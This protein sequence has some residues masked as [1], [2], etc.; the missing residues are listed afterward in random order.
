MARI[1]ILPL[2][3]QSV[4]GFEQTPFVIVIDGLSSNDALS[5]LDSAT[6]EYMELATGAAVV[7]AVNETLDVAHPLTL[8]EEQ[9]AELLARLTP[10]P[11]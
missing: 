5:Q 10:D 11:A 2:P 6:I 3:T 1:Q 4:G 8:S 7:L 9:Q